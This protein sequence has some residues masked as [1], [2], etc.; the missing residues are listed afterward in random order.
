MP[1]HSPNR[2]PS[3]RSP[4]VHGSTAHR[5]SRYSPSHGLSLIPHQ[6]EQQTPRSFFLNDRPPHGTRTRRASIHPE[7]YRSTLG[8]VGKDP[9]SPT[10][11][12]QTLSRSSLSFHVFC[13]LFGIVIPL[14]DPRNPFIKIGL[15]VFLLGITALKRPLAVTPILNP[16]NCPSAPPI[17]Q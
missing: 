8:K 14:S 16:W 6:K 4:S 2:I 11:R 5:L 12:S 10:R 9:I 7:G 17:I 15:T 1:I 3:R 13:F